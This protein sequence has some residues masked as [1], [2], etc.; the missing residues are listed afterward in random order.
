MTILISKTTSP[1][2]HEWQRV[3]VSS[4]HLIGSASIS[5]IIIRSII[6]ITI[7]IILILRIKSH[8]RRWWRGSL[9]S[10]SAHGRLLFS[11]VANMDIH[12]IQRWSCAM[13]SPKDISLEEEEGADVGRAEWDGVEQEGGVESYCCDLN[14]ASL[15]FTAAPHCDLNC[16]NVTCNIATYQYYKRLHYNSIIMWHANCASLRFITVH[17]GHCITFA[18]HK[19]IAHI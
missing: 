18:L 5:I 14:C 13:I 11:Y 8:G 12:L 17:H 3:R 9:R 7:I 1:F 10:K 2:F 6:V 16:Y 15:R 19:E 4:R